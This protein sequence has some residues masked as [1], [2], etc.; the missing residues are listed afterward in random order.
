E[1]HGPA[2]SSYHRSLTELAEGVDPG[3]DLSIGRMKVRTTLTHHSDPTGIGF[4]FKTS[5]GKISYMS[6]SEFDEKVVKEHRG[7]RIVI[8][9]LTRPLHS[10]VPNHICTDDAAEIAKILRP[11]LILLSHFGA[12]LIY[13]G[14]D[15]QAR[16]VEEQSGIRTVAAED[17]M[18]VNVGKSI[19]IGRKDQVGNVDEIAGPPVN[20]ID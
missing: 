20:N 6:D 17:L 3:E 1:G 14:T 13:D 4:I 16:Y 5:N 12:K 19:R 11:E 8:L 15:K 9:A 10:R 2:V 18:T 7:S